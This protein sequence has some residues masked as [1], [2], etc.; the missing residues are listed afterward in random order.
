MAEL[1]VA[2][3]AASCLRVG[4]KIIKI[5][6]GLLTGPIINLIYKQVINEYPDTEAIRQCA[7]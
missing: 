6:A 5:G 4:N 1:T 7:F 2:R 3:S